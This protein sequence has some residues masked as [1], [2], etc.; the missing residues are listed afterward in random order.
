MV[1]ISRAH[2]AFRQLA[3][4]MDILGWDCFLEGRIPSSLV[5]KQIEFLHRNNS[6]WKIK[7]WASHLIQHLLSITH[8]QWLYRNARLYIQ[9]FEGMPLSEHLRIIDLVKDMMLVDPM[10]L[11]PRHRQ[12][13]EQDYRKLGQ[14]S[15]VDRK[16][17]LAKMHSALEASKVVCNRGAHQLWEHGAL[18]TQ[19]LDSYNAFQRV[20]GIPRTKQSNL[21]KKVQQPPTLY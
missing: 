6:Y 4:D 11:L 13:L 2:P 3:M 12:L 8:R 14:G 19:A 21:T 10:D 20:S 18:A 1:D 5:A 7:T 15:S 17:W 16:L 9:K